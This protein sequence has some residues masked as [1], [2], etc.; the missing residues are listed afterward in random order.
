MEEMAIL[1]AP[2]GKHH[3]LPAIAEKL[4]AD[5]PHYES[6]I[7]D[8]VACRQDD[9]DEKDQEALY[10]RMFT[11]A[12][13]IMASGEAGIFPLLAMVNHDCEPNARYITDVNG[14]MKLRARREIEEGSEVTLSY[15][16]VSLDVKERR[17][18]LVSTDR[19]RGGLLSSFDALM[20]MIMMMRCL[21]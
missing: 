6:V 2:K 12:H 20:M 21:F 17:A 15:I 19:D 11:N 4:I 10:S 1:R 7:M 8:L 9:R 18:Q 14:K 13:E 5:Q 3:M 16:D